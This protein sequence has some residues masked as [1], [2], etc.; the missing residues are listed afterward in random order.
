M[1]LE[2]EKAEGAVSEMTETEKALQR[3]TVKLHIEE[4]VLHGFTAG[5]HHR[6]SHAVQQELERLL[7][8]GGLRVHGNEAGLRLERLH[9][10]SFHVKPGAKPLN[11]GS[12]IARAVFRS[13]QQQVQ[14]PPARATS[15]APAE[16][17]RS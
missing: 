15:K 6:V 12:E 11:L 8:Q 16:G 17:T 1:G 5:D 7:S 4:L 10:G 9:A 14:R 3:N 13:V 2:M